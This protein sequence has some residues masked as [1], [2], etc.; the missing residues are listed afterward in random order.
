MYLFLNSNSP[1]CSPLTTPF[2]NI[3]H[4]IDVLFAS[5]HNFSSLHTHLINCNATKAKINREDYGW[6]N[7][8]HHCSHHQE[9][10]R[11]CQTE[12]Y[13]QPRNHH[14]SRQAGNQFFKTEGHQCRWSDRYQHHRTI[15]SE[16]RHQCHCCRCCCNRHY[17][18]C[19]DQIE[20]GCHNR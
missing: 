19:T 11:S 12:Q 10:S 1:I 5:H 8:W 18:C 15:Q 2:C 9:G 20:G 7:R 4:L 14:C 17:H 3:N 6:G 16:G 13:Q